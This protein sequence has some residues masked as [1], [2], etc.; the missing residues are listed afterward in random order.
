MATPHTYKGS[1]FCGAIEIRATGEPVVMGYC[2]CSSCRHWSASPINAFTLWKPEA[3]RVTKG[4]ENLGV[5]HKTE[6][7]HRKWCKHCGGHVLSEHPSFGLIDVYAAT[8]PELPFLPSLHV[9]YAETVLPI[10]DGLPKQKD[11]PKEM[12]GSG[13]LMEEPK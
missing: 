9:Y 5:F 10:R 8:L 1:C 13:I 12:G 7:S 6:K 3:I 2:H 4:A 11:M